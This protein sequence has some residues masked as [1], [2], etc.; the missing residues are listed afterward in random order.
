MT[1]QEFAELIQRVNAGFDLQP[2]INSEDLFKK[3]KVSIEIDLDEL[4][5]AK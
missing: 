2:E 1:K 5:E 3:L 4:A